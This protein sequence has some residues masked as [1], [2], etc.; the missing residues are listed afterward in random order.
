MTSALP[1]FTPSVFVVSRTYWMQS[2]S[3]ERSED[4][5]ALLCQAI[6]EVQHSTTQDLSTMDR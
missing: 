5:E 2:T 6:V 1:V 3:P 4:S